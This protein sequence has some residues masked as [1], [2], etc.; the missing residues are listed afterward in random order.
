[1]PLTLGGTRLEIE[2]SEHDADI[3]EAPFDAIDISSH[4]DLVSIGASRPFVADGR[5]SVSGRIAFEHKRSRSTLL[6][7]PFSFSPG[8]VDGKA[9]G[10]ALVLGTQWSRNAPTRSLV[11]R[12]SIQLGLDALGSTQSATGP[13]SDFTLFFGQLQLVQ[14]L[15]WRSSRLVVR[16]LL[17]VADGSLLAMYKMPIG[18]RYTVRGYRESQLVRDDGFAVSA[19]F[20]FPAVVDA[21]GQP[22]G[23]LEI[24][25]FV[26]YGLSIDEQASAFGPR[27][28]H[29]TSVGAGLR[30]SPLP[31][32]R[33]ELYRGVPLVDVH[34]TGDSLQERGLHYALTYRRA[35]SP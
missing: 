21:T 35:F 8:D 27:R 26:D 20:Q 2:A 12:G 14:S 31:A 33:M 34:N 22:R 6:G 17:Q 18:G 28:Q 5:H 16:G 29:L 3:V 1:V 32:L 11:A 10:S 13:D 25:A 24:A 9:V 23:H 4:I 15:G 30:W 19:E 7:S